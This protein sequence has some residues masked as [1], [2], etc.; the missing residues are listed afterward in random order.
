MALMSRTVLKQTISRYL[1]VLVY[2]ATLPSYLYFVAS[3]FL[4]GMSSP[5]VP[6]PNYG[7]PG[8]VYDAVYLGLLVTGLLMAG[9]WLLSRVLKYEGKS[10]KWL[11]LL[12][13]IDFEKE[14]FWWLSVIRKQIPT[15]NLIWNLP[16]MLAQ[17]AGVV[18]AIG[19]LW[20]VVCLVKRNVLN[21]RWKSI[22]L[23]Q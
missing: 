4:A 6:D 14:V 13:L 15:E 10:P 23:Q 20:L 16:T 2:L 1:A 7:V 8:V 5:C 18:A 19:T 11:W 22:G 12:A 9:N 3:R 17:W 21:E